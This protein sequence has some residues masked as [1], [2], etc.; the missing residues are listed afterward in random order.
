[1]WFV[2]LPTSSPKLFLIAAIIWSCFQFYAGYY[3]GVF[4]FDTADRKGSPMP[5]ERVRKLAYGIHHGAMYF[6][7][8]VV[9]FSAWYLAA[10]RFASYGNSSPGVTI[11]LAI[12]SIVGVS[13]ALPRMLYLGNRPV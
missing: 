2:T 5:P 4:I 6:C 10:Y 1:M 12:I 11:A 8:A 3:Y 9:G 7:C 13:G